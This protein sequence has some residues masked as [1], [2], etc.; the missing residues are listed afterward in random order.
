MSRSL[1]IKPVGCERPGVLSR[2]TST[3]Q[4]KDGGSLLPRPLRHLHVS[5]CR[6]EREE[7]PSVARRF[8]V[9][10]RNHQRVDASGRQFHSMI[11]PI[12]EQ[13]R[14]GLSTKKSEEF[15]PGSERTLAAWLRHASRTG[16][17]L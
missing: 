12:R 17:D 14:V 15:D 6:S 2:F 16:T 7:L 9:S 5:Q 13:S 8:D 1:L 4:S 11:S 10:E 3:S